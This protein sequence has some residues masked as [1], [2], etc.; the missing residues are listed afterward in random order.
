MAS[1]LIMS[2]LANQFEAMLPQHKATLHITHNQHLAYNI[3]VE[4]HIVSNFDG[5]DSSEWVSREDYDLA[6][7][8]NELWDFQVY[9]NTPVEFYNIFGSSLSRAM[10][11]LNKCNYSEELK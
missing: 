10:E 11:A 8:T 7:S 9:P 3:T 1:R 2:D 6:V 5:Y 4:E